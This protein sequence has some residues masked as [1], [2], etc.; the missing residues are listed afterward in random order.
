VIRDALLL[1]DDGVGARR[2]GRRQLADR[3]QKQA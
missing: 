1:A 2:V 3:E